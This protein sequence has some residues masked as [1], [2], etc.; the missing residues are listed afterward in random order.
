MFLLEGKKF[1]R[2]MAEKK[3]AKHGAK[4]SMWSN[5]PRYDNGIGLKNFTI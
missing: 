4:T 1:K 3:I 2:G 5:D